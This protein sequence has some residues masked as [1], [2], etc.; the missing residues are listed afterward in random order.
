MHRRLLVLF[1]FSLHSSMLQHLSSM[2]DVVGP[3]GSVDR[4]GFHGLPAMPSFSTMAM[5]F[6]KNEWFCRPRDTQKETCN[7][8]SGRKKSASSSCTSGFLL[9]CGC[10]PPGPRTVGMGSGDCHGH[11]EIGRRFAEDEQINSQTLHVWH[12]CL[13]WGGFGGQC[14]HI[15]HTWSVWVFVASCSVRSEGLQPNG[16]GLP[17]A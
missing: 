10:L 14:R 1:L 15:W 8:F 13:H 4:G 6:A 7:Q 9:P 16:N 12:I 3:R 5:C 2:C 11:G 17:R